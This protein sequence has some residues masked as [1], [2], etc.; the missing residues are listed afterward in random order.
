MADNV[1]ITAGAGTTVATDDVGGFQFQRVKPALG[2]DG[3]AVDSIGISAGLDS[4]GSGVQAVGI[5]AQLDNT[6]TAT[7]TENQ[8][9]PLRLK[10]ASRELMVAD[11]TTA[12]AI[13]SSALPVGAGTAAAA[14]RV[15]L[16][17]DDPVVRPG[18]SASATFTPAAASHVA[19]DCN[20]AAGTI[21]L[22]AIS[23]SRIVITS[24]TLEIDGATVESTA[25]RLMLYN[26]TP[27]S[28]IA[29]DGAWTYADADRSA[30]LGIVELGTAVDH[31]PNQWI[32]Q[33]GLNKQVKL[34]GTSVF[35]YL[36]N[37][38]TLTPQN[39]AH[40]V[41]LHAVQI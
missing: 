29:D 9:A 31:G 21:S 25:W 18:L 28:A 6:A 30:F 24:A 3:T 4:T 26:V 7:V 5:V 34:A 14:G 22:G 12:A 11:A 15:T 27:P 40:I 1:A 32:E 19:N 20:G 23:A 36:V 16:A 17:S 13:S 38:T 8:F 2:A 33:H 39:V 41:T 35:A 37:L 10:D